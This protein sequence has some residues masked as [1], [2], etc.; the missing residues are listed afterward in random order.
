MSPLV[1]A[2]GV[3]GVMSAVSFAAYA[4]D[5]RR[6]RLGRRRTPERVL[7]AIDALGGFPGGFAAQRLI[8]HKNR[9]LSYQA[10]FWLIV[11]VHG[12]GW[13]FWLLR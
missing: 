12:A 5:K 6:A 13:A 8:R 11:L 9:K 10:V 1:V 4:I 2:L 3:Y 7:L